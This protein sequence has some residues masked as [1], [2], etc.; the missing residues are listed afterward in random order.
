M[1]TRRREAG[2]KEVGEMGDPVKGM[3]RDTS[4]R[5]SGNQEG[6]ESGHQEKGGGADQH[7][8]C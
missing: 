3:G 1:H 5:E 8:S 6:V 2:L 4:R 7:E